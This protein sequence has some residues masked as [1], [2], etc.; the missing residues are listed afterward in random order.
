MNSSILIKNVLYVEG[1]VQRKITTLKNI[2]LLNAP[3]CRCF[4][5]EYLF[6]RYKL[7]LATLDNKKNC[8]SIYFLIFTFVYIGF[9]VF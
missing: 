6:A 4:Q 7:P 2:L 8:L 9:C 5:S 1:S 3:D